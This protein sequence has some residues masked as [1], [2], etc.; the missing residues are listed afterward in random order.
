[1]RPVSGRSAALFS[2]LR[3]KEPPPL[4]RRTAWLQRQN[5]PEVPSMGTGLKRTKK[6]DRALTALVWGGDEYLA[7]I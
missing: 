6:V 1:M 4:T 7:E 3:G 2:L 5:L